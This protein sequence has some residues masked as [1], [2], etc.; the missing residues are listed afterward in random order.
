[1]SF[2]NEGCSGSSCTT[3][4]A[5]LAKLGSLIHLILTFLTYFSAAYSA[6]SASTDIFEI[7][8]GATAGLVSVVAITLSFLR[9]PQSDVEPNARGNEGFDVSEAITD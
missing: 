8:G 2:D 6:Y 3:R 9:D 1:M 4:F 7:S 5:E